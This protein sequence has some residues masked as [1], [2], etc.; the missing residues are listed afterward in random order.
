MYK[1]LSGQIMHVVLFCKID[2]H[3]IQSTIAIV[4]EHVI[5]HE[6][7]VVSQA[8]EE[9]DREEG[10]L[11]DVRTERGRDSG[12]EQHN[13]DRHEG[14]RGTR[15]KIGKEDKNGS[16]GGSGLSPSPVGQKIGQSP[17]GL[18]I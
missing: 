6:V 3:G 9:P 4:T 2:C 17:M 14:L 11:P 8:H 12:G 7:G 15:E 1:K 18:K 16:R 5:R 10:R 13:V